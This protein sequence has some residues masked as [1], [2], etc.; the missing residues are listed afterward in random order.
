M[1]LHRTMTTSP[2]ALLNAMAPSRDPLVGAA[3]GLFTWS[4]LADWCAAD[5][6]PCVL[7]HALYMKAIPGGQATH[8]TLD[9]QNLAVLRRGGMRPQAS[10]DPAAL[11]ATRARRRR[12]RPRAHTRGARLAHG[13]PTTSPDHLPASGHNSADQATR[14]GVAD[15]FADPAVHT[16]L[17]VDRSRIDDDAPR[18]RDGERSLRNAAQHPDATTR[19]L[20]RT[21]PGLGTILRRG[22]WSAIHAIDRLPRVQ[23]CAADGRLVTWAQASAGKRAGTAGTTIGQAQLTWAFSDAAVFCLRD[24]PAGPTGRGSF[25]TTHGQGHALTSLAHPLARAVYD[26]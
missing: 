8:D 14:D 1:R 6:L 23:A 13:P 12:R 17:A 16:R 22:R 15:R 18:L 20:R 21:G 4:W 2:D 3:A 5:G 9:A 7:G 11:R 25:A 26:R 10:V 19:Y 24:H